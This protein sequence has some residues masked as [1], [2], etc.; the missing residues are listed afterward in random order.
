[1]QGL[2]GMSQYF[3]CSLLIVVNITEFDG[4]VVQSERF[5]AI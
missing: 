5:S 1:M 3:A 2:D 4:T